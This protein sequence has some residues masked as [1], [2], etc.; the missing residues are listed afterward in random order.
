MS[1]AA[2]P[3]RGTWLASFIQRYRRPLVV[4]VQLVLVVA[5]FLASFILADGLSTGLSG[6]LVIQALAILLPLR[7]GSMLYFRLF[8]GLW[9]YVGTQDLVQITKAATASS[10]VF[11]PVAVVLFGFDTFLTRVL[12]LD[13]AG[14]IFLLGGIRLAARALRER[15]R[16]AG[17]VAAQARRLLIVGA[18]DAGAMLCS[19]ALTSPELR[20]TPVAFVD[21]DSRKAGTAILGIPIAGT[22]SDIPRIVAERRVETIVIAIP[23]AAPEEMR[24]LVELCQRSGV[25]FKT[26]P[27][28][29]EMLE[30]SVYVRRIREVD[31]ADLLGRPQAKLD[32]TGIQKLVRGARVLVTGAAGSVG[33]ELARQ[34]APLE[35]ELLVLVDRAENPL[36]LLQTELAATG[37]EPSACHAEIVDVTDEQAVGGLM[38]RH[39]PQLVFHAAAYKH[40]TFMEQAPAGA[41]RNNIGGT[42][43]VAHAAQAAGVSKFVLV[44]T[45]KAVNPSSVMGVTKR[46]AELMMTEMN[47]QGPTRFIAVRF[48]NVL[49]SAGSVVPVFK[50]QIARGGPVTVTHPDARRYFMSLSEAAELIMQAAA[51]GGGGECFVL[52]MGEPVKIVEIAETLISLSGLRPHEDIPIVFTGLQHGEKMSEELHGSGETLE[53][54]GNEKLRVVRLHDAP[55][56]VLQEALRL[57]DEVSGLG[58]G[59]IVAR[60]RALVPEYE[61]ALAPKPAQQP[62]HAAAPP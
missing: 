20:F 25:P 56:D 46:V 12:F 44:S 36:R 52:E 21:D 42:H 50:E 45:D 58:P 62:P 37:A 43:V 27:P 41:V 14:N 24:A 5:S 59:E 18:G 29:P 48:G 4:G 22:S 55:R 47:R 31:L 17:P 9:R 15:I 6:T 53:P 40:V 28:M 60:L 39:R 16:P 2:N 23:S 49:G 54:T 3:F 61:P 30:Q 8:H 1:N 11:A 34:I 10:L 13:W 51:T 38:E 32:R 19:Q 57:C 33:S 26:L 7:L 35:P